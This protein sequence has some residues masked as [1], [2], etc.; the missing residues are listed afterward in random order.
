MGEK[1]MR[2]RTSLYVLGSLAAVALLTGCGQKYQRVE[3]SMSQP[4][5][6][7][8]ARQ[9]IQTL[10]SQ[11]VSKGE[12]AA[13]GLSYALPTTIFIGAVTGTGGAKYDVGSGA[14][15]KKIDERIADIRYTCRL[16]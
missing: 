3:D 15:N 5:N 13:A 1:R 6:C 4:I 14:F 9:E 7:A 10:Q 12:E 2:D 11:K 8:T 16:D